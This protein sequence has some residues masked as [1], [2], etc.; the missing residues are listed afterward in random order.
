MLFRSGQPGA[1]TADPPSPRQ[2]WA[3]D[4]RRLE[5]PWADVAI[6]REPHCRIRA[7]FRWNERQFLRD[8]AAMAAG[9]AVEGGPPVSLDGEVLARYSEEYAESVLLQSPEKGKAALATL[10]AQIPPE[11]LW[12]YRH[13]VQSTLADFSVFAR[14]ALRAT[15]LKARQGHARIAVALFDHCFQ[16]PAGA[17]E[18]YDNVLN[19]K[20]VTN[21]DSYRVEILR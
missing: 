18:R 5:S 14:A 13:A 6:S 17:S 10:A 2:D 20:D 9:Y 15:L 3:R 12:L 4:L 19:L 7:V 11:I 21:L 8:Q 1:A 16:S